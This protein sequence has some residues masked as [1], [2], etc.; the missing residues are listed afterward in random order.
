MWAMDG[1]M[2]ELLTH[3]T[4]FPGESGAEVMYNI[5]RVLGT[6][7]ERTWSEG[8]YLASNIKYRFPDFHGVKLSNVLPSASPD[9]SNLISGLLAWDPCMRPAATEALQYPFFN[10]CYHV[11]RPL[12]YEPETVD[13]S[14]I[15]GPPGFKLPLQHEFLRK[16]E[17]WKREVSL[18]VLK[19]RIL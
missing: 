10:T 11:S 15:L 7:T 9:L 17:I 6:P 2:A 8:L 19:E 12:C 18:A 13:C 1:I 3:E 14:L 4:L 5:C 16:Q